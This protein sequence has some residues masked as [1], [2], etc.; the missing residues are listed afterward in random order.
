MSGGKKLKIEL[1]ECGKILKFGNRK[2]QEK[3]EKSV[4]NGKFVENSEIFN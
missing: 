1:G 2:T 3:F 4:K